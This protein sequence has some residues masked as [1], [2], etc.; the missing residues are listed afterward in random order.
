MSQDLHCS[1]GRVSSMPGSFHSFPDGTVCDEHP[2][3]PAVQRIQGETDSFGC[4]YF[5][6]CQEC[7]DAFRAERKALQ[8]GSHLGPCSCG[9]SCV[10]LFARRDYDE[11]SA[12]PLYYKCRSCADKWD[13]AVRKEIEESGFYDND[14]DFD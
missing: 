9:A 3:R 12:G 8:G 10:P 11:G 7:L 13:A 2:D 4:E 5:C 6:V 14:Y 1:N